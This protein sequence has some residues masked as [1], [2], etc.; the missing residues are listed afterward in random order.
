VKNQVVK[1][2]DEE[3]SVDIK[4]KSEQKTSLDG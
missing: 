3:P 2:V 4:K 1:N